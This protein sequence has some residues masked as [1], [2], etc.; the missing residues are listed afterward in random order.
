MSKQLVYATGICICIFSVPCLGYDPVGALFELEKSH[1]V[2][3]ESSHEGRAVPLLISLPEKKGALPVIL[4]SHG[5]G[6]SRTGCEYIRAYWT[7]RGYATIFLQHPGSDESLLDG[8]SPSQ[9]SRTLRS[10]ATRK[11]LNLRVDDV[12]DVLDAIATWNSD[13]KSPFYC[14]M[15]TNK[16]GL[17]GH[18]MGARTAQIIIGEQGWLGTTKRDMRIRAAVVM[19]P[20]SPS[21]QSADSAFGSVATPCLLLTGTRDSVA[22]LSNQSVDSRRAVFPALPSGNAYELVLHN[23][24]H[25]AFTERSRKNEP[26]HNPKH[27]RAI[28]AITTAFWDAYLQSNKEAKKW[29][30][31]GGAKNAIEPQDTWLTK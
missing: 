14:R 4:F 9:V 19:S 7:A 27:H 13:K 11:N 18:S 24:T 8:L 15:N 23:A 12:T 16:V 3:I 5:L 20:S 1:F 26:P 22:L 25:S 30:R 28:E 6:G 10:A 17:A 31:E 2:D 21:L 29:L